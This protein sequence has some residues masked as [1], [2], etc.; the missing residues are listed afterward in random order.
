[1]PTNGITKIH[2]NIFDFWILRGM[3]YLIIDS[4]NQQTI[5]IEKR[6]SSKLNFICRLLITGYEWINNVD[7]VE[8]VLTARNCKNHKPLNGTLKKL[9]VVDCQ[10]PRQKNN[11]K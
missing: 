3:P 5:C 11:G 7:N 4:N 10:V 6:S 8:I 9:R 1:M 2:S